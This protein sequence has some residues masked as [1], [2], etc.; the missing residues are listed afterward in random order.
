MKVPEKVIARA[1]FVLGVLVVMAG[2]NFLAGLWDLCVEGKGLRASPRKSG[3]LCYVW[4]LE[5][6]N[7]TY[8]PTECRLIEP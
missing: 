4:D 8:G 6:P 7:G 5:N 2:V 3:Q 1:K